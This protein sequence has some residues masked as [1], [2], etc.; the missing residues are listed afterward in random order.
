MSSVKEIWNGRSGELNDEFIRNYTR[1]FQVRTDSP[2][3]GPE[4][5]VSLVSALTGALYSSYPTDAFALLKSF[6]PQQDSESPLWW[7]VQVEY[8][9]QTK[10]QSQ[11]D[12][13]PWNRPPV[14]TGSFQKVEKVAERDKD[15]NL[16][17][18][19]A[20]MSFDPPILIEVAQGTVTVQQ[21]VQLTDAGLN[22]TT[23]YA[24][25]GCVNSNDLFLNFFPPDS[26]RYD[27]W[28]FQQEE[29]SGSP[30]WS[31][32]W[33]FSV[34]LNTDTFTGDWNNLQVL[35]AGLVELVDGEWKNIK[36]ANG[37][38]VS[39]P[40]LLDGAGQKLPP[41][42]VPVYLTVS[43]YTRKDFSTICPI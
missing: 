9:S 34:N 28:E 3:S 37:N 30:Y 1:C 36:D 19:S 38:P 11:Q 32:K 18:N 8:S 39:Q 7:T 14:I 33:S 25:Y 35:D 29:F 5:A 27:G 10:V 12:P 40:V 16:I 22:F 2:L 4:V 13:V 31:L 6:K 20:I 26:C 41:A 21:N 23:Q 24:C 15:G 42:G 43:P 17:C